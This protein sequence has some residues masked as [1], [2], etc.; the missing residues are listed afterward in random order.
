MPLIMPLT[1][2]LPQ[3]PALNTAGGRFASGPVIEGVESAVGAAGAAASGVAAVAGV[4]P[5]GVAG[6][7]AGVCPNVDRPRTK[8]PATAS[9]FVDICEITPLNVLFT[10]YRG[11]VLEVPKGRQGSGLAP[12]PG[13]AIV[14]SELVFSLSAG[15]EATWRRRVI[16]Y[17][18]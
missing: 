14:F 11:R 18:R 1:E 16:G 5:A 2:R 13:S 9:R 17:D 8:K 3:L 10:D 12:A 7:G 4:P 6:A 15:S